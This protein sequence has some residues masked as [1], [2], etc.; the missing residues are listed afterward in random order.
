MIPY[1]YGGSDNETADK[2]PKTAEAT[3]MQ[4]NLPLYWGPQPFL[5]GPVYFGA[6]ICFLFILGLMVVRSPHKWWMLAVCVLSILMSF[7]KNFAAFNYF[8]FDHL[9]M[10]NKFRAPSMV[11]ILPQLLFPVIGIMTVQEIIERKSKDANDIWKKIKIAGAITIGICILLGPLGS[12]FFDYTGG[13]DAQMQPELVKVLKED[14]ASLAAKSGLLSAFYILIAAALIWAYIK[15]KIKLNI[16]VAGLGLM[17]AVDLI[18]VCAHYL[19]GD[20]YEELPDYATYFENEVNRRGCRQAYNTVLQDKDPYFRVLDLSQKNPYNDALPA[21]YF[22]CIGGYHPAKIEAYQDLIDA[23]LS[24]GF[25]GQVL[26]M[27]NT[28]YIFV[29]G[30]QRGEA[31]VIPNPNACGNAWFVNEVKWAA[32]ADEEL[33][34][35]K[36]APIGDTS[37]NPGD[38]DPKK[39]AIVRASFKDQLNGY[40]MG[41]DSLAFVRLTQYGLDDLSFASNN[42]KDGLAVF[43]DIYYDHGWEAYVDGKQTPIIKAN[44]VL[45]AIKIPAGQHKIEFH[46]RPRSYEKGNQ[47]ALVS[48][49]LILGLLIGAIVGLFKKQASAS[50]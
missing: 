6:I 14:R 15:D 40:N 39:T 31:G 32:S 12:M 25:N 48:S 18:P 24:S 8:L 13:S 50:K 33:A 29:S 46:F 47:V 30:N 27:L 3:N 17:I 28:K 23:H 45:R 10:Y 37:H 9:P 36:A 26:N 35:M 19:G 41:K 22:K 38:F 11:L 1:L 7:G 5:Q 34:L 49:I 43:S 44:Y 4:E 2:A 20:K 21:Y 42:S 16:L